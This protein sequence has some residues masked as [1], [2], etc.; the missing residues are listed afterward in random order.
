MRTYSQK[1]THLSIAE[2]KGWDA[3]E[4]TLI[5]RG[6]K[7]FSLLFPYF[8]REIMKYENSGRDS[9]KSEVIAALR[10]SHIVPVYAKVCDREDLVHVCLCAP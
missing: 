3:R 10:Q 5:S 2:Q 4:Q 9:R 6:T 1:W 8:L 7:F